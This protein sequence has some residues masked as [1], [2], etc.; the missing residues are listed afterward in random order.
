[1]AP[2][3]VKAILKL[4]LL[5]VPPRRVRV[6]DATDYRGFLRL[7]EVEDQALGQYLRW[8]SYTGLRKTDALGVCWEEIDLARQE[9]RRSMK[10][11]ETVV[12]PL[13]PPA[14]ALVE[15]IRASWL[16]KKYAKGL[17]LDLKFLHALRHA[18]FGAA[19]AKFLAS[20]SCGVARP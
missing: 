12:L 11:G 16:M 13:L 6:P 8:V 5:R 4:P 17:D 14:V 18:Y 10:G 15:A 20:G 19:G 3:D 7:I 1:M 9:Y 2:L